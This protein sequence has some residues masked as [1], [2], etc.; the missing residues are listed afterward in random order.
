M[1]LDSMHVATLSPLSQLVHYHAEVNRITVTH[2]LA[3][4]A[5]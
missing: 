3:P 4:Q 2:D 1:N 5:D